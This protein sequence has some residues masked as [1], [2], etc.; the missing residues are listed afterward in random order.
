MDDTA[1]EPEDDATPAQRDEPAPS[2]TARLSSGERIVGLGALILLGTYLV[3]ELA[4]EEYGFFTGTL[5]LGAAAAFAIWVRSNRPSAR[6]PVPYW[7][8][9]R[10]IGYAAGFLAVI[11]LLTDLRLG[12][13]DRFVDVLAALLGYAGA[14]LMFWGSRQVS[15]EG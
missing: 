15:D 2:V 9:L 13:L 10:V 11:E 6:W 7:W 14:F 4:L 12:V 1:P 3:F 5:L 8:L